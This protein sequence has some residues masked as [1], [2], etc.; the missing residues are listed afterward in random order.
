MNTWV[1][2]MCVSVSV[3]LC[4]GI[5]EQIRW[6]LPG[7]C[8]SY[9]SGGIQ[10]FNSGCAARHQCLYPLSHFY[11]L[12]FIYITA[13]FKYICLLESKH[14]LS[15]LEEKGKKWYGGAWRSMRQL[16]VCI[17]VGVD[18][19]M[20]TDIDQ[21]ISK[22]RLLKCFKQKIVKADLLLSNSFT[23]LIN[24]TWILH[25]YLFCGFSQTV[26]WWLSSLERGS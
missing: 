22:K 15:F 5:C 4:H 11:W 1:W 16:C 24:V 19:A 21:Y 9:P 25:M 2:C 13:T 6:K 7:V 3:F 18:K 17:A 23:I 20:I 10:G 26:F 12:F 8:I 14:I